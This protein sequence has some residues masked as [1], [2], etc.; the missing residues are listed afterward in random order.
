MAVGQDRV[1]VED[2]DDVRV[3]ELGEQAGFLEQGADVGFRDAGL[4]ENLQG[5]AAEEAVPDAIH[6]GMR[7]LADESFDHIGIAD[8]LAFF[9]QGHASIGMLRFS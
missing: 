3:A 9:Q 4:L 1:G 8:V 6:L 5:L 2:P 7:A